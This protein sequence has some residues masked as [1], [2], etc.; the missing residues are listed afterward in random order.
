M[1]YNILF[2]T[3]L[4]LL[5][6]S[7]SVVTSSKTAANS[8][9]DAVNQGEATELG[10]KTNLPAKDISTITKEELAIHSIAT[11]CWVSYD[12]NVYDITDWLPR[13]PG[14]A[15]AIKP[16]CGTSDQFQTAFERQHGQFHVD[17]LKTEGIF[18][19]NLQ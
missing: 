2:L 9:L 11:D 14:S 16:Y 12:G 7:C 17:R 1:K 6:A 19:G 10:T 4:T 13:H 15:D 8:A 3:I 5:I 18:K